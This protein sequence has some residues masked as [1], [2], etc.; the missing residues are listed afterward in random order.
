MVVVVV[1]VRCLFVRGRE[2]VT[3][4]KLTSE[5]GEREIERYRDI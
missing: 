3:E 1:V 2:W 4:K 5:K